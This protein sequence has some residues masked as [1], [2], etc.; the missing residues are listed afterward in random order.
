[1]KHTYLQ[2]PSI[3]IE[4]IPGLG[5]KTIEHLFRKFKSLKKIKKATFE[6]LKFVVGATKAKIILENYK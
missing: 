6:E 3:E 2:L 5:P 4:Q 1:M